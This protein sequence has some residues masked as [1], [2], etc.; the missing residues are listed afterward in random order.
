MFSF[1][2]PENHRWPQTSNL[3]FQNLSIGPFVLATGEYSP[4]E[5]ME[6]ATL[7]GQPI[8]FPHDLEA[9]LLQEAIS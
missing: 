8:L 3:P 2:N 4:R 9:R 1:A 7:Q 5:E 6:G